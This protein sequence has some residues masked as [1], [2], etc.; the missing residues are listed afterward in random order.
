MK[1][2]IYYHTLFTLI[3]LSSCIKDKPQEPL[4]TA[5]TINPD[6]KVLVINEGGFGYN[7]AGISLYD[8]TSGAVIEDYYKQQNNNEALGDVCQSICKFNNRYY[9]VMNNSGKIVVV[10]ATDLV[11]TGVITGFNSPRYMLPVTYNKA[12]VSDL[13]SNSIK[14]IDLN[15][16]SI[17]GSITC[18]AGTEEMVLIYNKAFVT[19]GNSNYCYIINTVTDVISDSINIGK[20]GTSSVIDKNSKIWILPGG[21]TAGNQ[22]GKLV[23]ID[24]VNLQIEL[25]LNF[26]LTDSP[27]SLRI[28][29]THDTLYFLNKG[30]NRV[31]ISDTQL[32]ISPLISQGSKI[33]YGLGINPK[34]YTIYVSDAIDYIQKSKIEIYKTDGSFKTSFN[35]GIISNGFVFE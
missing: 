12:Y 10:N 21:S 11:K 24:P 26:A 18:M 9:A 19:N 23:R 7:N 30:I 15:T 14:V 27:N 6:T 5:T 20:G 34:D 33:Y 2:N 16:N 25:S 3:L 13:Y 8:P 28:N 35:A 17:K 22:S 31:L 29:K 1:L 4:K 32:P